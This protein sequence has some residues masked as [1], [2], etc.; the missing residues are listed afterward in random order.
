MVDFN[1]LY[2]YFSTTQ[3]DRCY[4]KLDWWGGGWEGGETHLE[5]PKADS[6]NLSEKNSTYE[7]RII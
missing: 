5:I 7:V 3:S 4:L 1:V 6:R 2:F